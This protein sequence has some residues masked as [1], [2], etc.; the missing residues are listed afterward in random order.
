[1]RDRVAQWDTPATL[2]CDADNG[3]V[4]EPRR[5]LL[6]AACVQARKRFRLDLNVRYYSHSRTHTR[7]CTRARKAT[8]AHAHTHTHKQ[9]HTHTHTCTDAPAR[10]QLKHALTPAHTCALLCSQLRGAIDPAGAAV[11]TAAV[12]RATVTLRKAKPG[13]WGKLLAHGAKVGGGGG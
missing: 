10:A 8:R 3:T 11:A 5:F 13:V 2:G 12:G 4:E 9:A 1:M 6:S 7:T